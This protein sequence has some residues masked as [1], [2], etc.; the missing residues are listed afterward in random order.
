MVKGLGRR[1][2]EEWLRPLGLV[3][4]EET[5]GRHCGFQHLHEGEQRGRH[6]SL[7]SPGGLWCLAI[8][9][10]MPSVF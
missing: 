6:R 3:S 2:Y 4:L 8:A 1:S 9:H 10:V 5:E 7:H